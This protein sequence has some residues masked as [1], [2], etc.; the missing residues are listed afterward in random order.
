MQIFREKKKENPI[1]RLRKKKIKQNIRDK[2]ESAVV[3]AI[4]IT[5]KICDA[6]NPWNLR[7]RK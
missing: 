6:R 2:F 5:Q 3:Q 7:T 4:F 1:T